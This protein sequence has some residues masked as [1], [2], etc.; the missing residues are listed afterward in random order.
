PVFDGPEDRNGR[1]N[2]D[3]LGFWSHYLT[4][5]MGPAPTTHYV[6]VAAANLDPF[7][8]DGRGDAMQGFSPLVLSKIQSHQALV[9]HMRPIQTTM[10]I[11][12]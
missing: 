6:L 10:V 4:G 5:A 12:R 2:A 11:R 1:R 9:Q 8:G 3:E 7:D